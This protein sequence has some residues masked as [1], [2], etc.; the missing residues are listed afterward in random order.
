MQQLKVLHKLPLHL[1]IIAT[2]PCYECTDRQTGIQTDR[3]HDNHIVAIYNYVG[4]IQAHL[5]ITQYTIQQ[6]LYR[7]IQSVTAIIEIYRAQQKYTENN[8]YTEIYR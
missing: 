5:I 3:I 2:V 7:N 4:L 6:I 1:Q 8:Y